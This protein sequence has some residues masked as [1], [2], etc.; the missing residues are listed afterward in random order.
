MRSFHFY[1]PT[2][3][4]FGDEIEKNLQE[5]LLKQK[6]T[7]VLLITMEYAEQLGI[8]GDV[9]AA[10]ASVGADLLIERDVLP[11]PQVEPVRELQKMCREK[12]VNLL[13]AAGGGSVIDTAK[14]VAVAACSEADPWSYFEG[15]PVEKSLPVICIPTIAAS[16][17]E[18]SN[19]AILSNGVYKRGM[20]SDVI[21][22]VA[23]F[24]N[25]AYTSTL[26]WFQT[27]AGLA[28]ISSHLMERYFSNDPAAD[29]TDRQIE[30]ALRSLLVQ[31]ER[32]LENPKD[33]D[34]RGEV[35]WL[36]LIAHNNS[37]DAGREACWGSHRIEHELSGIYHL[38]H[39]EGMAVVFVA[40]CRYMS[41]VK[42]KKLAQLADRVFGIDAWSFDEKTAA[43]RLADTLESFYKKLGLR[44]KLKE[45]KID[46][47]RFRE[48]GER[49]TEN[50]PVGHYVP[51]DADRIVEILK[52]AL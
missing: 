47:S 31:S 11:N 19:A 49:A 42:P 46:E 13:I 24:L 27:A 39:G 44:T 33:L 9:K 32:L 3:I 50:G 16:G 6:A 21:Y 23:A 34:A 30:G 28:D 40:W 4:Y 38:T 20:E 1:N 22:P 14:S 17:S 36:A 45:F 18:T 15:A 29:V 52:L 35:Q 7:K 10:C 41:E 37:M 25:P 48:M 51:L 5:E 12:G 43:L 8:E 2:R 26:P